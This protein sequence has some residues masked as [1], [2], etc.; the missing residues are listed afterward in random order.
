MLEL[1]AKLNPSQQEAVTYGNGPMLVLAGAG[2][3]KTRVITHRI[4]HLI[5][6][7]DIS[8]YNILAVTFTNKAAD[9]MKHRVAT[10]LGGKAAGVWLGTFHSIGLRI[11]RD[12]GARTVAGVNGNFST[13]DQDDRLAIVKEAVNSLGIDPKRYTPKGYLNMISNYKNTM[14]YVE[15]R[16]PEDITHR[17]ADV[18]AGYEELLRGQRLIDFDDMLSLSLRLFI[19]H[20]DILAEYRERCKYILV[21]EYQ[22]TNI[23]QFRF[24]RAL[25]GSSGNICVV[26]DDDQSIYSWRGAEIDNI[27]RF[28]EYFEGVKEIKLTDNYRS[29]QGILELANRLIHHNEERRGKDLHACLDVNADIICQKVGDERY[30]AVFVADMV[31]RHLNKGLQRSDVAVLYRTNAQSRN[32]EAEFSRRGI[33]HKVIGGQAFYQRREVKDVLSYLR[34]IDNPYDEAA[35]SRAIK[36]PSR[37]VG[38]ALIDKFKTYATANHVD[39]LVAIEHIFPALS[40]HQQTGVGQFRE[41]IAAVSAEENVGQMVNAVIELTSYKDYLMRTEDEVEAKNR[42][43]NIF[44][45]YN[46][47]VAANEAGST[48]ADFLQTAT[49]VTSGDEGAEGKISLMTLH[50]AKGL[51]FESVFITGLEEG[52]FPKSSDDD[53]GDLEEERRLCYV[54]VTRAKRYL[55]LSFASSRMSYGKRQNYPPSRF[56]SELELAG[57]KEKQDFVRPERFATDFKQVADNTTDGL[58]KGQSV[59]HEVFG[60]G[61]VL[62]V[63]GAGDSAKVDVMFK[64]AGLKKLVARFLTAG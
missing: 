21:D 51:E 55:T 1:I 48:L 8:P 57:Y 50:G 15:N 44:E 29:A 2:T 14:G 58:R 33:P 37:G 47:A 56:I 30:E 52:L 12:A 32:F 43:E 60:D 23:I 16:R 36:T 42:T 22:D 19:E 5:Q 9:E 63:E 35:F 10:L 38:D 62:Q 4:A 39:L 24:L 20:S 64:R 27:L 28:D 18:F 45:L 54:G 26:G 34:V 7:L 13:V 25:A 6:K 17:F 41:I 53:K 11:L 61:V 46:A 59:R 3:G 40:T 49:L 31:E